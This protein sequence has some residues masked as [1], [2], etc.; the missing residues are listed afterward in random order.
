MMA[1]QQIVAIIPHAMDRSADKNPFQ[2]SDAWT[3]NNQRPGCEVRR[4]GKS[5]SLLARF[6]TLEKGKQPAI[7]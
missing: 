1:F 5:C 7:Y 2:Y 6:P 4:P 3:I